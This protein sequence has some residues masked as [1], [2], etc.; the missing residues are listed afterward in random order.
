M[1][2]EPLIHVLVV[3]EHLGRREIAPGPQPRWCFSCRKRTTFSGAQHIP[4]DPMSYYGAYWT[5]DCDECGETNG[6]CF[7]G[8]WREAI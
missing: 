7:P 2:A 3:P 1:T 4:D 5:I 6:D 8:T